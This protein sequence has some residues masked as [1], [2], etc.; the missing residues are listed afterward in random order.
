MRDTE[1][2]AANQ[3]AVTEKEVIDVDKEEQDEQQKQL[4]ADAEIET[5]KRKTMVPRSDAWNHF[6]KVKLQSGEEK[7]K[8]KYCG[9]LYA[10]VSKINGTPSL[11]ASLKICRKNQ[12]KQVVDKQGIAIVS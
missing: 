6:I 12:N 11:N 1:D 2:K 7:A 4:D 9:G 3:V 10:C 8:C 5:K